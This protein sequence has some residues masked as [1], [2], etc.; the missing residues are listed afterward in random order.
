MI[1]EFSLPGVPK[2]NALAE[3][4]VQIVLQG[5]RTLLVAAGAP[6]CFW[7]YAAECFCFHENVFEEIDD[8]SAEPAAPARAPVPQGK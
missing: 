7:P 1:H 5:T 8:S 4:T 6:I 3:R 2:S